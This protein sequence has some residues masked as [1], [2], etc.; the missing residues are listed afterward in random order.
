M[1]YKYEWDEECKQVYWEGLK[2]LLR[3]WKEKTKRSYEEI[4]GEEKAEEKEIFASKATDELENIITK[5]WRIQSSGPHRL[6]K[7]SMDQGG[8][9]WGTGTD[10]EVID[11]VQERA[12]L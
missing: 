5:A 8:R 7:V 12:V 4:T 2:P 11:A 10:K 6:G 1:E 9:A 3:E